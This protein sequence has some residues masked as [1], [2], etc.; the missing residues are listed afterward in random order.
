MSV[1]EDLESRRNQYQK[2]ID[3][4]NGKIAEIEALPIT[5][6]TEEFYNKHIANDKAV[7]SILQQKYDDVNKL[8]PCQMHL[9]SLTEGLTIKPDTFKVAKTI[10][11]LPKIEFQAFYANGAEETEI[12]FVSTICG[13]SVIFEHD[14]SKYV[15]QPETG[16]FT[17][18]YYDVEN[19]YLKNSNDRDDPIDGR[20]VW[21]ASR[22]QYKIDETIKRS[23]TLSIEDV[24][25][26]SIENVDFKIITTVEFTNCKFSSPETDF[27]RYNINDRCKIKNY[28]FLG[29]DFSN[30]ELSFIS[31]NSNLTSTVESIKIVSSGYN[32]SHINLATC[33]TLKILD[34]PS[35]GIAD[36]DLKDC[37]SLKELNISENNIISLTAPLSVEVVDASN[38]TMLTTVECCGIKN[39]GWFS[40]ITKSHITKLY[41]SNCPKLLS[42]DCSYSNLSEL[43]IEGNNNVVSINVRNTKL[44]SLDVSKLSRLSSL[45]VT[46]SDALKSLNLANTKVT[47]LNLNGCSSLSSL[48]VSGCNI[49]SFTDDNETQLT[50]DSVT[51]NK[52]GPLYTE[53]MI[54]KYEGYDF[55]DNAIR[56]ISK[57]DNLEFFHCTFKNCYRMFSNEKYSK[58]NTNLRTVYFYY[59][60]FTDSTEK[61]GNGI[62]DLFYK[63]N[64]E[65]VVFVG[66]DATTVRNMQGIFARCYQLRYLDFEGMKTYGN[67][68]SDNG[69]KDIYDGFG[70]MTRCEYLN[71]YNIQ[72]DGVKKG[73]RNDILDDFAKQASSATLIM[74]KWIITDGKG[75]PVTTKLGKGQRN[76]SFVIGNTGV[77]Y[78]TCV[79]DSCEDYKVDNWKIKLHWPK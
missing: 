53:Y 64:V 49:T 48:N 65:K 23:K 60:K 61:D 16:T 25:F 41:I 59:C 12:T 62:M 55:G 11:E 38:N 50:Y 13:I 56:A 58:Y 21:D 44:T 47:S 7:V 51:C 40:D 1:Q 6:E 28:T 33:T 68:L 2:T 22:L 66:C 46:S 42:L 43:N 76:F 72:T 10:T 17:A 9:I 15:M 35:C 39:Y 24:Y 45:T 54:G 37:T 20:D 32:P 77:D 71:I 36:I 57:G 73:N 5:S 69:L 19:I 78:L 74:P 34:V 30:N 63:S 70:W 14:G 67:H 75:N 4:V 52:N 18:P 29:C 31:G 79:V 27:V 8:V 26:Y 3:D